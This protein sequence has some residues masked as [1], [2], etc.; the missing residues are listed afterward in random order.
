MTNSSRRH[1]L[2]SKLRRNIHRLGSILAGLSA[3]LLLIAGCDIGSPAVK[4]ATPAPALTPTW[5]AD[6][7]Q[8]HDMEATVTAWLS[9]DT[10][11]LVVQE[12]VSAAFHDELGKVQQIQQG[13]QVLFGGVVVSP[14]Y[15]EQ[16]PVGDLR[17]VCLI[18]DPHGE[19]AVVVYSGGD[20]YTY[21]VTKNTLG[22][23]PDRYGYNMSNAGWTST[24]L[25]GSGAGEDFIFAHTVAAAIAAFLD[26]ENANQRIAVLN[27]QHNYADATTYATAETTGVDPR[28]LDELNKY[29]KMGA[30]FEAWELGH[31]SRRPACVAT[32]LAQVL[33]LLST[34]DRTLLPLSMWA[35]Y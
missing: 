4:T 13:G 18:L 9:N 20:N 7:Q 1:A 10:H 28:Y 8:Y 2:L 31:T 25:Q 21:S 15:Q 35:Q 33:T 30:L 32:S 19:R 17:I 12:V 23:S 29:Y 11:N 14:I 24:P 6:P 5:T 16:S 22:H 26:K 27:T 3:L 34:S